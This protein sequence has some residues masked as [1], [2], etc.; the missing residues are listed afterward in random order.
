MEW[1]SINNHRFHNSPCNINHEEHKIS[2]NLTNITPIIQWEI[3][4]NYA[5]LT[6]KH[7]LYPDSAI[8]EQLY[9]ILIVFDVDVSKNTTTGKYYCHYCKEKNRDYYSTE[10]ALWEAHCFEEILNWS[11]QQLL[12]DK[13]LVIYGEPDCMWVR[14]LSPSEWKIESIQAE[15]ILQ[16]IPILG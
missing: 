6:V 15:N 14:L 1:L 10:R 4:E 3:T 8:H 11:N 9:D 7:T 2:F 13:L 5:E 12:S 16:V